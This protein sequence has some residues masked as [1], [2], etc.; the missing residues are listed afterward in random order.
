VPYRTTELQ[1]IGGSNYWLAAASG[2]VSG[3]SDDLELS[4]DLN[5]GQVRVRFSM[6]GLRH[7]AAFLT[8]LRVRERVPVR[9]ATPSK[10]SHC[11]LQ[12][13]QNRKK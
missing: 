12:I 2:L 6:N 8:S 13:T 5:C 3:Q 4:M 9:S 11:L 10:P 7:E 1:C